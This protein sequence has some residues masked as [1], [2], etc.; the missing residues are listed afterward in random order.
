MY[1]VV[2]CVFGFTIRMIKDKVGSVF[3]NNEVLVTVF[4]I[5]VMEDVV[6]KIFQSQFKF[7]MR[8][9]GIK[10]RKVECFDTGTCNVR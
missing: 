9:G 1:D 10:C 5:L 3:V 7:A 6:D 2:F 4:T 8:Y